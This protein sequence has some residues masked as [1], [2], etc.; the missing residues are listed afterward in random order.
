VRWFFA[1]CILS[2]LIF[3]HVLL[4]FTEVEQDLTH[5]AH[6]ENTESEFFCSLRALIKNHLVEMLN[7]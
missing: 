6:K 2:S 1:H 7:L 3:F 5:L 4:I